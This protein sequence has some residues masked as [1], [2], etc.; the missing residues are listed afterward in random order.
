MM[1]NHHLCLL[2]RTLDNFLT[3]T[4]AASAGLRRKKMAFSITACEQ[5][6]GVPQTMWKVFELDARAELMCSFSLSWK[7]ALHQ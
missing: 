6:L 5:I 2:L 4:W 3:L 7:S 1:V